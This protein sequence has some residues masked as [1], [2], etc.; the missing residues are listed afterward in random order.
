MLA[1][2]GKYEEI[3]V[4]YVLT[5]A[6]AAWIAY[7]YILSGRQCVYALGRR[8]RGVRDSRRNSGCGSKDHIW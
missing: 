6:L 8:V 1:F 5:L 4:F 7:P 2:K 3:V